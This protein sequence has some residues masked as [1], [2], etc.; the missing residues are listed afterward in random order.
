MISTETESAGV[1]SV[2]GRSQPAAPAHNR[3]AL[4]IAMTVDPEIPV[5]PRLYGG[6]ERIVDMLVRGLMQRG[7]EVTLFANPESTVTCRLVPYPGAKSQNRIDTLA[8]MWHVSNAIRRGHF[9]V[10]HSFARLAYL[11][12]LL[13]LPIPKIMSYQ[14]GVSPRSVQLGNLL[15]RGTL[16]F[17]AC[18][19]HLI[20]QWQ[21]DP[22]FHV[23]YNGV[24]LAKYQYRDYVEPDAPLMY[25][26]RVEEIKGVHLAVK[27]AQKSGRRL[28][29]AGNVPE[30]EHHHRYFAER[31]QPYLK[32]GTIEY[33]GPVDDAAKN[34]LLGASA[35]LLMPLLWEEPFGI[36]MAEALA[37][38]TP[39]IGLRRGSLP[40][41]VESGANGFVCDS[42]DE[43][44]S[45][46]GRIHE[47][48]R[49]G[50]RR[51]A[52]QR[53][54]DGVIVDHYESLY[55]SVVMTN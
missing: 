22:H 47:I 34:R 23:I 3:P 11:T 46:V 45:A 33:V 44:V 10:V 39:V 26:G 55:R 52:E 15:S 54:S 36:V 19:A 37:C 8:N 40:E 21:R 2:P 4:R 49:H 35:A 51:I 25:L 6:I 38:G 50:C 30:A 28:I 24:P 31:I 53:F 42:V 13:P 29:I 9:D 41:I 16:S 1:A 43:M 32:D 7:H 17:T 20:R 5:P 12:P 27:V 14:R 18:G 48:D